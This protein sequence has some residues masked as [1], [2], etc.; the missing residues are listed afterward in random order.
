MSIDLMDLMFNEF[1]N[2]FKRVM[3]EMEILNIVFGFVRLCLLFFLLFFVNPL[4]GF[5]FS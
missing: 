3:K 4:N 2:L 1:V 5:H